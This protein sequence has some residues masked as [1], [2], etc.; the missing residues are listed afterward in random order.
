MN[1]PTVH[2]VDDDASL[3]RGLSRMLFASGYPVR[4]FE[5][6]AEF[7]ATHGKIHRGCVVADLEMP[8]MNGLELQAALARSG[9]PL[10]VVFL[11]GHGEISVC[12][13]AMKNG[14]QDFLTKPVCLEKLVAAVDRAL[15][16]DAAAFER[17]SAKEKL[18]LRFKR[19]TTR[20]RQV[21]QHVV[22]GNHIQDQRM[23]Y[24]NNA[25]EDWQN[26]GSASRE[27]WQNHANQSQTQRQNAAASNQASRQQTSTTN[28]SQRQDAAAGAQASSQQSQAARQ[29]AAQQNQAARQA[30][31][32]RLAGQIRRS[33][34]KGMMK[35]RGCRLVPAPP[36][37][38]APKK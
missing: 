20:E 26:Y 34:I 2:L 29:S 27:D 14:A 8:E 25:R 15:A 13:D 16:Q 12:V 1:A 32:A 23:N 31:A 37:K 10:P 5:S 22:A 11:T 24:A 18:E 4:I 33:Y 9:N 36:E 19:L 7:L 30:A 35:A 3:L 38:P 28:Q 21:L 6:A 17:I